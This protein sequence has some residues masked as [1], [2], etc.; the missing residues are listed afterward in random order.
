MGYRNKGSGGAGGVAVTQ[1]WGPKFGVP[2][3]EVTT[4][5]ALTK[6][7]L[8]GL[9]VTVT[10]APVLSQLALSGLNAG[11]AI[12]PAGSVLSSPFWQSVSTNTRATATATSIVINKPSGTVQGDLM[13][14]FQTTSGTLWP[15]TTPPTG[16]TQIENPQ[17]LTVE[18]RCWYKVA[19]AS[20]PSTYTWVYSSTSSSITL[21]IHRING[22]SSSAPINV[23]A[24]AILAAT[25]AVTDPPS[26]T[27]T[28]TVANCLVFAYIGHSHLA[29]SSTHLPATGHIERT[30][31]QSSVV[32]ANIG[33]AHCMT[34]VF[35]SAAVT[36][37]ATHDCTESVATDAAMI[38]VAIAPGS[39]II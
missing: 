7:A 11:V 24:T 2:D 29:V 18:S 39:I 37:T 34:K 35:G 4:T 9:G 30:D 10:P 6:L 19:G 31:F 1:A 27:V 23:S 21:E 12:A 36:G 3:I 17:T 38:R 14:A 26:P 8:S 22:V 32:A 5:P 20:E 16:W 13:L 15:T 25:D 28:T 33:G